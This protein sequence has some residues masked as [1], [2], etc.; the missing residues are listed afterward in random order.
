MC[1]SCTKKEGAKEC[2]PIPRSAMQYNEWKEGTFL[3][4]IFFCFDLVSL[5]YHQEALGHSM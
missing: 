3:C 5:Y 1:Q 2:E 4:F